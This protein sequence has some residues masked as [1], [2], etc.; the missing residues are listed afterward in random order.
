MTRKYLT[1]RKHGGEDSKKGL[2]R[3]FT[4]GA[5]AQ[6][7]ARVAALTVAMGYVPCSMGDAEDSEFSCTTRGYVDLVLPNGEEVLL[8]MTM[9]GEGV[10]SVIKDGGDDPD[11]TDGVE[12]VVCVEPRLDGKFSVDGAEGVGRVT[13]EGLPVKPGLA[14]INPVPMRYIRQEVRQI[15]PRGADVTISIPE[16]DELAKRTFNPKLGIIGGLSI[17]GTTGR[18]EPWSTRAYQES[19]LPQL[20]VARAAGYD[21]PMLVPGAKGESAALRA[22]FEP[23]AIVHTGNFAGMMLAAARERGISKVTLLGHASKL[24]KIAR[25]DF[26]TH[27]RHSAMPLDVLAACAEA[28]GWSSERAQALMALPTTEAALRQLTGAGAEGAAVL[29]EAA[30]R[31]AARVKEAYGVTASVMLT[32][33]HGDIVGQA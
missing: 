9:L 16:G 11:V 17:L 14:A 23:L 2:R 30:R 13:L 33:S 10:A 3:G 6:A 20:D 4:T 31:V 24:A 18:V 7:A 5:C 25:G 19:L 27:S 15:L 26:D 22:G 28:V 32:D 12:I 29:D 8:P 21:E 1:S